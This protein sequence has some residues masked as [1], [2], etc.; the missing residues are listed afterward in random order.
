MIYNVKFERFT[1]KFQQNLRKDL[2]NLLKWDRLI[3]FANKS[4]NIYSTSAKSYIK[5]MNYC[6]VTTWKVADNSIIDKINHESKEITPSKSCNIKNNKTQKFSKVD[7]FLTVKDHKK[8]FSLNIE[9][10]T[11]N[12]GKN[13]LG[14]I[15]KN[16]LENIVSQIKMKTTIIQWRN[17]YKVIKWFDQT[18]EKLSKCFV[19]F[20]IKNFYPRIN[21]KHYKSMIEF[22]IKFTDMQ[23]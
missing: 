22:A 15:S 10:K 21:L 2:K 13:S 11:I 17:I 18:D 23:I 19:N 8:D 6:L 1:S 20:D 3:E 4:R 7:A 9:C 14:R 16:I 12:E 5:L